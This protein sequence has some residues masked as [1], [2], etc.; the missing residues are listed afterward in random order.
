MENKGL[1]PPLVPKMKKKNIFCPGHKSLRVGLKR[2]LGLLVALPV[3]HDGLGAH[4][5]VHFTELL[6]GRDHAL[7][8]SP[9]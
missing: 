3:L 6:D 2:Q 5:A 4:D 9:D 8:V 7:I 1:W